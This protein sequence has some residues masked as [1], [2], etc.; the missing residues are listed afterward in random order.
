MAQ[1]TRGGNALKNKITIL[2]LII[3]LAASIL[4]SLLLVYMLNRVRPPMPQEYIYEEFTIEDYELGILMF[5]KD[6]N[7]GAIVDQEDAA[8]K[9]IDLWIKYLTINKP[10][11]K[12]NPINGEP[13]VVAYDAE[14]DCWLIKGTLPPEVAG[15]VPTAIIRANGDV[16]AVWLN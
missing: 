12:W 16:V 3:L 10:T 5:P 9:G 2:I 7:V 1:L 13:V 15:V 6:E 14:S 11:L 4:I 8:Q